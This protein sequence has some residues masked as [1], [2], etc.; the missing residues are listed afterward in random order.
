MHKNSPSFKREKE[1][2][3]LNPHIKIH[4]DILISIIFYLYTVTY[5]YI[6]DTTINLLNTKS[7][8]MILFDH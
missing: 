5:L 4:N 8:Q 6:I 1:K 3:T 7:R 2:V